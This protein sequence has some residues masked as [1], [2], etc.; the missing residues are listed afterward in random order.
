MK[1]YQ[2][3]GKRLSARKLNQKEVPG[4]LMICVSKASLE[5]DTKF[6]E[7]GDEVSVEQQAHSLQICLISASVCI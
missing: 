4:E 2:E 3:L 1:I 6:F 7:R 5:K